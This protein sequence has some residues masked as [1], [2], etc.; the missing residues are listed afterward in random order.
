MIAAG[1]AL[2]VGATACAASAGV[3][4]QRIDQIGS[5]GSSNSSPN[6]TEPDTNGPDDSAPTTPTTPTVE[7]GSLDWGACDG[8]SNLGVEP[9]CATLVVPLDYAA[10]AGETIDIAVT[11]F[12]TAVDDE[13]IGSL[14]FNP[15]GPG[16]SGNDFL[17]AA[18]LLVPTELASRF[19]L[20]SFDPR[21]V[22]DSTAVECDLPLDDE[23]VLLDEG[24]DAGWAALVA[25]AASFASTCTDT[26]LTIAAQLGTNNAA[27]DLD[28]LRSALGDDTL[29]YVGFSYGTR[30]GA[31]YAQLFPERV[32]ALVLDGAVKPTTDFT[33]LDAEQG[34][35]LD[36]AFEAFAAGC[37]GDDDCALHDVGPTLT[38]Y[39]QLREEIAAVGSFPAGDDRVL[40]PGELQLGVIAALYTTQLWPVLAQGLHD[41]AV[42]DDGTLLQVL[43]D[44]YVG[45]QLDGSYDNSQAASFAINC[46][47]DGERPSIEVVRDEAEEVAVRS[48]HF[49]DL[50][51]ASTGCIGSPLPIDPIIIGPAV[52]APPILVIGN[53]GDPA[54]PY[55]WAV[56]LAE[57][58]DSA[59][60]YTVD[61]DGHTAFLTVRCVDS[62]VVDYLV[63]LTMPEPGSSC[64][65][66]IGADLFPAAGSSDVDQVIALLD[67]LRE[68]G[69]D[70]PEVD[71]ADLLAD[72][73]GDDL[74]GRIDPTDPAFGAAVLAC[75][76][77]IPDS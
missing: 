24:D 62:V 4:T 16:A 1:L 38:V 70:I 45:R 30:L 60:L 59:E 33:E 44:T 42:S 68:H 19:D 72:P 35:S 50:L 20:V 77:L 37:D 64:S 31:T 14:V 58:L 56:E 46:A 47:D 63:D 21:G 18:A 73:S 25:D 49:D 10:P 34:A 22:G 74:L 29:S 15:G 7:A 17:R 26:T 11:R 23:V 32:R 36:R 41:A 75:A 53:T 12:A 57:H 2:T 3:S 8:A 76:D 71:I 40:T 55:E 65:A 13:R 61:A 6:I 54:T 66:D 39:D 51:R 69:A 5:T 52:G 27:R 48:T 28:E 43:V 67:C 9:Q